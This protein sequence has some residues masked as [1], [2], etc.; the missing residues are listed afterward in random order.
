MADVLTNDDMIE[1]YFQSDND[2]SEFEGFSDNESDVDVPNALESSEDEHGESDNDD[3]M[4]EIEW[5]CRFRDIQIADFTEETG[6]MFPEGFDTE[7]AS[8]K[9]YFD[10]M[11]AP[12]IIGDFVQHTNNYAKWKIEQK[13]SEDPVWYDVTE[14]ELRA[15]F[16]I[17]I[18]MG[19][20][21]LPRYKDYWSKDRFIGNE[22]I[23]SVMTSKRYEKITEY[24]HVS[25]RAT[26]R[27]RN[28]DGYDKLCKVRPVI[29]MAKERF[30]NSY[31]PHKHITIDEAMIKW[32][33]RLSFKQYLPAK[34]IKRGI[35]VWMRCDADTVFLTDFEI[36]LGR[37]TQHSEHGLGYD[38]VTNLTRDLQGKHF[39]LFFDNYFT[40][41][42]LAEDLLANGLY[43]CGTVR[44]NRRGFP[45]D[46]KRLKMR[47]GESR[48]RQKGNL[49]AAVWQDKKQVAF[50]STLSSNP[51]EQ[52]PVTRRLGRNE[53]NLRQ[54]HCAKEYNKFM[55]GV[56]R[57]DQLR[58]SYPLGRDGKKAWKYIFWFLMNC[59]IVNAFIVFSTSSRRRN[60]KKRYT[61]LDFRTELAHSLIAGF[62]GRKRKGAEVENVQFDENNFAGHECVHMNSKRRCRVHLSRKERKET[63]YGCKTCGVHLCKAGCH[64]LYHNQQNN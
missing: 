55:N 24:F 40:G 42:K 3:E 35:K 17:H 1:R 2:E 6:P 44:M 63:V 8:A 41:I 16:G 27:G 15:Y 53:L 58:M 39:H 28:D 56:D 47:R 48:I 5:S 22:G 61:H 9:D 46:L 33:G 20:N 23:K 32:T 45:D 50:L 43:S 49:I 54:P 4:D 60:S 59:A 31:K 11:F 52:V 62:S 64:F 51:N 29:N 10:L 18:F 25:D 38:V 30:S 57:H 14:N 13:G 21:E 37:A 7:K 19:I 34:P 12:E 26:E 36:Y